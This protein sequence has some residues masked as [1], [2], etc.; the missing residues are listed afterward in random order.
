MPN[1]SA[2]PQPEPS[3]DE[4]KPTESEAKGRPTAEQRFM[5]QA[6]Q[7]I[8]RFAPIG[9]SSGAFLFFA[10]KQEWALALLTFPAVA[11]TEP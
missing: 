5:V 8:A 2:A 4:K 10:V 7:A 9:G 11:V 1:E 6:I 3:Q